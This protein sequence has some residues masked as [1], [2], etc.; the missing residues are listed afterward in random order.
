MV[1]GKIDY[2]NLL[3]FHLQLK[4]FASQTRFQQSVHY[5]KGVPA[6]INKEFHTRRIDAAFIS[7]I[8]AQRYAKRARLGIVARKEVLSVIVI[9]SSTHQEDSESQTSNRLARLLNI[10]GKVLIGDKALHHQYHHEDGIDLAHVWHQKTH[11]P[12][13]F[14]LLCAHHH[15]D[16]LH[17]IEKQLRLKHP[18]VPYYL[19]KRAAHKSGLPMPL[20]RNYL[21]KISYTLDSK[22]HI[23]LQRFY[24]QH[25]LLP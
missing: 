15:L 17:R 14:A 3:P 2:L 12:F 6:L 8:T 22:A 19:L 9:A 4:R 11:L 21:K 10:Q 16:F 13:V 23:S 25:R 18:S 7:S 20:I 1:F 24:R 5:K